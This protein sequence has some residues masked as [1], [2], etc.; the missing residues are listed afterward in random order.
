[1]ESEDESDSEPDYDVKQKEKAKANK[2]KKNSP[3]NEDEELIAGSYFKSN[4]DLSSEDEEKE[5]I[6]DNFQNV[7]HENENEQPDILGIENSKKSDEY[8][9][10][11]ERPPPEPPP[12]QPSTSGLPRTQKNI[13]ECREQLTIRKDNYAYFVN[14]KGEPHGVGSKLMEKLPNFKNSKKGI[15]QKLRK[16]NQYHFVLPIQ[17]EFK[18]SLGE[19]TKGI[20]L[21]IYSLHSVVKELNIK[22][23][24]IAKSS[25][26]NNVL[27]EEI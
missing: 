22:S 12:D 3:K 4:S 1:M 19:T 15:V 9:F 17:D 5:E 18:A 13:I 8:D 7:E 26:L 10:T 14:N 24:S 20:N 2:K 11:G 27:W 23:L 16:G 6:Q 21:A 25:H